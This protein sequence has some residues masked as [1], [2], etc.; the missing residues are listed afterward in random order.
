MSQLQGA[1]QRGD[2]VFNFFYVVLIIFFCYFY[3]AVTF[4]PVDVADN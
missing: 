2:W 1:L 4:Q 3:T